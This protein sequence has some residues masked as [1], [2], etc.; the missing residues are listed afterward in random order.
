M[1]LYYHKTDGGAEY[2]T[3]KPNDLSTTVLRTDGNELEIS[4]LE[5]LKK[6]GFES[7]LFEGKKYDLKKEDTNRESGQKTEDTTIFYCGIVGADKSG[8][9]NVSFGNMNI[10]AIDLKEAK[11]KA[12][13]FFKLSQI[14]REK[15]AT[16]NERFYKLDEPIRLKIQIISGG[17][18]SE[19]NE[20]QKK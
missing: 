3:T 8:H 13:D 12:K 5:Q 17:V 10:E 15:V 14:E 9:K 4:S 11:R 20:P 2:Y 16:F 1:E 18:F 7:V 6:A 19:I